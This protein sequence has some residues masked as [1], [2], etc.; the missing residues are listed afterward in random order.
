MFF[1]E[2]CNGGHRMKLLIKLSLA[3]VFLV[4]NFAHAYTTTTDVVYDTINTTKLKM[5]IYRPTS[6]TTAAKPALVFIHGGCFSGGSKRDTGTYLKE[7]AD[8]G[9][10]VFS[11]DY[12]LSGTAK[13]PAA[14]TDVQ[15]AI[16]YIRKNAAA[17]QVDPNKI[18]AHG[19]SAGAYLASVLGVKTIPDRNGVTDQYSKRVALVLDWYGRTDFTR[20]QTTGTDCAASFLGLARTT[21]N[22][23]R[24]LEASIQPYVDANSA[25]FHIIHGTKDTQVEPIHSSLLA[26]ALWN[27]NKTAVLTIAQGYEHSFHGGRPWE[28]TRRYV[29]SFLGKRDSKPYTYTGNAVMGINSGQNSGPIVAGY[30]Y[31]SYFAGGSLYNYPISPT[32]GSTYPELYDDARYGSTFKYSLPAAAGLYR[33]ELFFAEK[34]KTARNQRVFTVN[35]VGVPTFLNIDIYGLVGANTKLHRNVQVL[36]SGSSLPFDFVAS[37]DAAVVSAFTTKQLPY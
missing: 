9:F 14:V 21:A 13:Y 1:V 31:D 26:N 23:P 15:Q 6:T 37:K 29:L 16:R 18:I 25:P 10:V 17:L 5:D 19:E 22:A 12:R 36:N 24:F 20:P 7:F 8:E 30:D 3:L 27:I 33:L 34:K 4:S 35:V 32:A 11:L 2:L 28:I